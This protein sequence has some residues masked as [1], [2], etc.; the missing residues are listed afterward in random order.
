MVVRAAQVEGAFRGWDYSREDP[1]LDLRG[2]RAE[3]LER[4]P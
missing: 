4:R 3:R 1:Y 2:T